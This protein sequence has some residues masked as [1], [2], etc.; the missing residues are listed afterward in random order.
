MSAPQDEMIHEN[1]RKGYEIPRE[2]IYRHHYTP[3]QR[4]KQAVKN[5]AWMIMLSMLIF[6]L[7]LPGL[8]IIF[9]VL[10]L[11]TWLCTLSLKKAV[12]WLWR[13]PVYENSKYK[14]I[15]LEKIDKDK[16]GILLLGNDRDQSGKAL[17]LSVT[18]LLTHVLLLGL[19]GSGKTQVLLSIM[20]QFMMLNSGFIFVDGKGSVK[21][22]FY[23]YSMARDL[24]ME[25]NILVLNFLNAGQTSTRGKTKVSNTLNPFSHGSS[26]T[27]MEMISGFMGS[28]KGSNSMWRGR[29][30]ALGRCLLRALCELRDLGEIE[31]SIDT[32][33]SSMPLN[34]LDELSEH[35]KLSNF[36]KASLLN[37][38]GEL[39]AWD[40]YKEASGEEEGEAAAS[41]AKI[42]AYK[43]HGY[44]TMQFT[45]TLELLSGTYAHI[46]KTDLA[47]ID[48]KDV[49][50]NRRI[51]YVMLPSLEKSPESLKDI[52][53]M[54]VTNIRNAL[55]GLLGADCLT[56]EKDFLLDAKPTHA[57]IPFSIYFDE[58]GSYAV[59]GTGDIGAQARELNVCL[60]FAGQEF[61]SFKKGSEIEAK[62]VEANTGVKIFM[63][64]EG[65][66]T[67]K[68]ANKRAGEAYIYMASHIESSQSGATQKTRETGKYSVQKTDRITEIDLAALKPG[69]C[70]VFYSNNMWRTKAFY[71]DFAMSQRV[72]VN[73]FIKLRRQR[74]N[75][76]WSPL[77]SKAWE[78]ETRDITHPKNMD[79]SLTDFIHQQQEKYHEVV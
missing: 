19:T 64:T 11:I 44:L 75:E 71:G 43:Q 68:L 49:I 45:K 66:S 50:A 61:D 76:A 74:S 15:D 52:G 10:F 5:Y 42:E 53:R 18:D 57:A 16:D 73:S 12:T 17:W 48:F 60:F 13:K 25:D 22:W 30:E 58:Y 41:E 51:L 62:R 28:E 27:L 39:P 69:E 65:E 46:T 79:P 4:F 47:D 35:P 32:I 2:R 6:T 40:V 31:L 78:K 54:V 7:F 23:L 67:V 59:E 8:T 33:R 24:G 1:S 70:Y 63:K 38:L 77:A 3:S 55:S 14:T 56:G 72:R 20:Y 26:D 34:K 21:T 37:Y 9:S 29:A 36:A